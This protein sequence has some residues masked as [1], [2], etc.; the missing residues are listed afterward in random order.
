M[1]RLGQSPSEVPRLQGQG[2]APSPLHTPASLPAVLKLEA[3]P[4]LLGSP[5]PPFPS[6]TVAALEFRGSS[7]VGLCSGAFLYPWTKQVKRSE[8]LDEEEGVSSPKIPRGK[9]EGGVQSLAVGR[10]GLASEIPVWA[11]PPA[12]WPWA[13]TL[14]L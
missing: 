13:A 3:S 10:A 12:V 4:H 9:R 14:P 1:A 8:L 11:T 7:H 2:Q 5:W 6:I